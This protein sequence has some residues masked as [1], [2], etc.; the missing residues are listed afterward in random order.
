MLSE[1]NLRLGFGFRLFGFQ[2][3]KRALEVFHLHCLI[4]QLLSKPLPTAVWPSLIAPRPGAT[5]PVH[6]AQA[7]VWARNRTPFTW[8]W[9]MAAAYW[10]LTELSYI[11]AETCPMLGLESKL[12]ASYDGL[13]QEPADPR[14]PTCSFRVR[15]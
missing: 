10:A 4:F 5:H 1:K 9:M 13:R 6:A 15:E 11:A 14:A 2:F 7:P 8:I 3:A 12:L